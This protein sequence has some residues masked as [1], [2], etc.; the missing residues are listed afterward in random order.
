MVKNFIEDKYQSFEN[1]MQMEHEPTH[2][3]FEKHRETGR[4]NA[5]GKIKN[6]SYNPTGEFLSFYTEG[7]LN[8]YRIKDK[9]VVY[10]SLQLDK[11]KWFQRHTLIYTK[12]NTMKYYSLYDNSILRDFEIKES[13]MNLEVDSVN[14]LV[15]ASTAS[16]TAIWDIRCKNPVVE[17]NSCST[18]L[19]TINDNKCMLASNDKIYAF[20]LRNYKKS[21]DFFIQ[22]NFYNS[23]SLLDN[24]DIMMKTE[25]S[26]YFLNSEG[27]LKTF[28]TLE[29]SNSGA[30]TPDS[31]NLLCCSKNYVF[32]YAIDTRKKL[33]SL[34]LSKKDHNAYHTVRVNPQG[35][36]FV[37]ASDKSMMLINWDGW[38]WY[39]GIDFYTRWYDKSYKRDKI[40]LPSKN[41]INYN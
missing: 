18:H 9:K 5:N 34:E 12:N 10:S 16:K 1:V 19:S 21:S 4:I 38:R 3:Y 41:N 37:V 32:S 15:L 26:Y 31:K 6:I 13:V 25:S 30:I 33:D 11:Y 14:D 24:G 39:Y 22:P 20:D 35:N 7:K 17:I 36:Q 27:E 28:I 23:I 40:T 29:N 2:R 8:H